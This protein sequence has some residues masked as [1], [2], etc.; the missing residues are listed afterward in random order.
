[1]EAAKASVAAVMDLLEDLGF[2]LSY[3]ELDVDFKLK[4]E[5]VE[6]VLGGLN[7]KNNPRRSERGDIEALFNS[8]S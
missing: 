2:R 4:N 8:P 7:R 3:A 6:E 1:M 5:M